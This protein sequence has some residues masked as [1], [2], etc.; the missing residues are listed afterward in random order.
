MCHGET[1]K[2]DGPV[3]KTIVDQYGYEPAVTPDLIQAENMEMKIMQ[4]FMSSGINVMP[5]FKKL[6]TPEEM[7]LIAEYI[8]T[9]REQ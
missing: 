4:T 7:E 3:L 9:L 8:M 1:A 6:L 2:G 5:S